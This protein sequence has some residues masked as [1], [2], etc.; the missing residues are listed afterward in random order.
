MK[1]GKFVDLVGF[2]EKKFVGLHGH[3]KVKNIQ[4]IL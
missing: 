2:I 3:M 1:F 4:Y